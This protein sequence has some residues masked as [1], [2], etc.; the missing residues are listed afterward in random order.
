M[1]IAGSE[2]IL[3]DAYNSGC[4]EERRGLQD[5][6]VKYTS[7]SDI[8]GER[9][10]LLYR[11]YR[12]EE[13]AAYSNFEE[14]AYLLLYGKL[15]TRRELEGFKTELASR[16]KLPSHVVH[17]LSYMAARDPII[18]LQTSIVMLGDGESSIEEQMLNVI[19]KAPTIVAY[20]YRLS[21]GLDP[22]PPRDDLNH[23]AN[24]LYMFR[25]SEPD[26]DEEYA[27][28]RY[29]LLHAEHE[30]AASTFA[31]IIVASTYS[32]L[33]S[34]LSAAM[35]AIKG[36]LHGGAVR[37]VY[38]Q[39]ISIGDESRVAK[40]VE[41]AIAS[42]RRVMGVGHRVY[43]TYDPRARIL[44]DVAE[45]LVRKRGLDDKLFRIALA[46]EQYVLNHSYFTQRRLYPNVDFWG[47]VVLHLLGIP[48]NYFIPIFAS[49][50]V[51]GWSAHIYEYYSNS[52][53][54][55]PRACYV[56]PRDLRYVPIEERG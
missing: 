56:G 40:F 50:R 24:F 20:H 9:G 25:G 37:E 16:R 11:G 30:L 13:L 28:D 33:Y 39:L 2:Q 38:E 6:V 35:A 15:P 29:L 55:R 45:M 36:K 3:R 31:A 54:I 22:I 12:I 23:A 42:G 46:L 41:D 17:H 34:A 52:R 14:V 19:A 49:A 53:L 48:S 5:V 27:L 21:R 8:D 43:K 44:K 4:S 51:V 18:A 26:K 7:I 47:A 10:V 32:D 1:N